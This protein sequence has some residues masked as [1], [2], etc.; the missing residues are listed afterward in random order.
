[1]PKYVAFL[2][3]INV[4]GHTVTM[5]TL[6]ALF[7]KRGFSNIETFIASGNVIFDS[8]K[9]ADRTL[10]QDIEQHLEAALGFSVATFVRT[11]DEIKAISLYQPFQN[12]MMEQV[13]SCNIGFTS[14]GLSAEA[15][16]A[17]MA[18]RT[19]ID[20]FHVHGR[21]VYWICRKKQS[22]STFSN[23]MFERATKIP[24]TFR[25]STTIAKLAAKYALP[26]DSSKKS[27]TRK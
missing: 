18:L 2:R 6:K 12:S 19:S 25:S 5:E 7:H 9:K 21:E 1:M 17:L 27:T 15:F 4:G 3:A 8:A 24:V 10:E 13:Q 11:I 26:H 23:R 20:D 22:E 14:D 16:T